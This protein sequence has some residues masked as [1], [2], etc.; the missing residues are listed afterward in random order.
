M[1][2]DTGESS[3]TES[4]KSPMKELKPT[5]VLTIEPEYHS[6]FNILENNVEMLLLGMSNDN[7]ISNFV[8]TFG[9]TIQPFG[10]YRLKILEII[11]LLIKIGHPFTFHQIFCKKKIFSSLMVDIT[12]FIN[13]RRIF[14]KIYRKSV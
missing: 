13:S 8:S 9:Q 3:L 12:I 7:L 2:K 11:S 10:A 4:T 6:F 14:Y 1:N 5:N